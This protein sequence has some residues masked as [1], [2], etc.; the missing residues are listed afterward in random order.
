MQPS[1][2]FTPDERLVLLE[3]QSQAQ[4]E[5]LITI[6]RDLSDVDVELGRLRADINS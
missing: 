4:R 3:K 1:S 2:A 6:Q 5:Q